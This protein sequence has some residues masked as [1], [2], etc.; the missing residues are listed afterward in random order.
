LEGKRGTEGE[1]VTIQT[2]SQKR[3][4]AEGRS[5]GITDFQLQSPFGSKKKE[6]GRTLRGEVGEP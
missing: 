1:G 5:R 6:S 4:P 2:L 3:L